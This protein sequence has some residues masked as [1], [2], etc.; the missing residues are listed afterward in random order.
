MYEI[1]WK[2][3]EKLLGE[4]LEQEGWRVQITRSS[5]DG[6]IDLIANM[7]DPII[8]EIKTLWQAKKFKETN[9]VSLSAVRELSAIRER[10]NATKGIM[11]TTSK[12]TGGAIK[13]IQQDR[14]RLGYLEGHQIEEWILGQKLSLFFNSGN[15]TE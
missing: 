13:W 9:K 12:L 10:E 5:K 3:F 8:G 11:V 4:L 7:V 15:Q 14:Y 1:H 2:D 6:G